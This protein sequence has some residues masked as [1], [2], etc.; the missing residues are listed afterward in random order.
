MGSG[1]GLT[2]NMQGIFQILQGFCSKFIFMT[3]K[4]C[5]VLLNISTVTG[6]KFPLE[7]SRISAVAV[8]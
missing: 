4:G 5:L 8:P 2:D 6:N 3:V 1:L 7:F